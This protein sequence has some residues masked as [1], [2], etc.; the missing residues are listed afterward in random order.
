M[1]LSQFDAA[2]GKL[3][4]S[5]LSIQWGGSHVFKVG[6]KIFAM[7]GLPDGGKLLSVIF[8][9]TP[10]TFEILLATGDARRASYLHRGNW[11][12]VI[13][14]DMTDRQLV[15]HLR[16]AHSIVASNLTRKVRSEIG[17]T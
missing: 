13:G 15:E 11:V 12:E 2:C 7:A 8:K 3:C 16:N 9:T 6:D 1:N 14:S 10:L 17:L 4:G 5:K